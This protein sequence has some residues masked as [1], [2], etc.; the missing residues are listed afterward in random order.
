LP[1]NQ[2]RSHARGRK[3][4]AVG[5]IVLTF[6]SAAT[7]MVAL[8]AVSAPAP[9]I[10]REKAI[11][12][13]ALLAGIGCR[14]NLAACQPK[15]SAN[16]LAGT[17]VIEHVALPAGSRQCPDSGT[18]AAC[19]DR[20]TVPE[21]GT[22]SVPTGLVPCPSVAGKLALDP[23]GA[24]TPEAAQP[25]PA[26]SPIS[27]GTVSGQLTLTADQG[28]L[29][30]GGTIKL[31]ARTTFSV[32]QTSWAIEIFDRTKLTLIAACPQSSDCVVEFTGK[33][34]LHDF[35]AY[36]ATPTPSVPTEGIQLTSNVVE[37]RWLG[38]GLRADDPRIVPP[39]KSV[40]FT[41]YASE[42]V[43]K[44]GYRV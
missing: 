41:A 36:L 31:D 4:S 15:P 42:E 17:H 25:N 23:P 27:A 22:S 12:A 38:I 44:I 39:G 9:E 29:A 7:Q 43:S 14:A 2:I 26:A 24:C 6:I 34:G 10:A 33:T 8:S 40:T 16:A 3:T 13:A 21:A 18:G 32:G 11:M 19:S 35:V 20:Q 1:S 28:M 37:V 30:Y 5:V